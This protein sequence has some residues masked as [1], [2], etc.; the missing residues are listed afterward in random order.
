MYVKGPANIY[1][2]STDHYKG[3][4]LH[5]ASYYEWGFYGSGSATSTDPVNLREFDLTAQGPGALLVYFS[6]F[7]ADGR[8]I[9]YGERTI[10]IH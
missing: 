9:G 4:L 5:E 1:V 3:E 10:L 6:A 7:D 2:G 8:R